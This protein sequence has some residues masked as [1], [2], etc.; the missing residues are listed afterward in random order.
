MSFLLAALTVLR[1]EVISDSFM[2][3]VS[4]GIKV[5]LFKVICMKVN[6][7]K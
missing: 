1:E 2:D 7:F 6:G 3:L 4:Q 5:T